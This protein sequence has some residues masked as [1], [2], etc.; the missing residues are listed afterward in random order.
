MLKLDLSNR[1]RTDPQLRS[2]G[3]QILKLAKRS[4]LYPISWRHK[5]S[6]LQQ[7]AVSKDTVWD[8]LTL[9]EPRKAVLGGMSDTLRGVIVSGG[10]WVPS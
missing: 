9:E 6:A 1:H 7:G 3:F 5:Q 10:T 8:R 2:I 4:W